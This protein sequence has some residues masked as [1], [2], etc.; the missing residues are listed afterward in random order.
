MRPLLGLP[1]VT[2]CQAPPFNATWMVAWGW[3]DVGV[4]VI[5]EDEA[6]TLAV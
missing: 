3:V 1:L 5:G 6:A 2:V 4:T